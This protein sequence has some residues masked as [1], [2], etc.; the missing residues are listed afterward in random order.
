MGCADDT[1]GS[2]LFPQTA[3]KGAAMKRER[4]GYATFG[5][6]ESDQP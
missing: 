6:R 3:A 5:L 4:I 1:H 2:L